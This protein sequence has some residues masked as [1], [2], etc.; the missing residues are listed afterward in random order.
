M[1]IL[2]P[3]WLA[4]SAIPFAIALIPKSA[5]P[6]PPEQ[7]PHLIRK[8]IHLVGNPPPSATTDPQSPATMQNLLLRLK[9]KLL[10]R[11]PVET[12]PTA[13]LPYPP[14]PNYSW[15]PGPHTQY[16]P[17]SETNAPAGWYGGAPGATG[18]QGNSGAGSASGN[19]G[20]SSSVASSSSS[21][22][23]PSL[24]APGF[25][26]FPL[27]VFVRFIPATT[28]CP[29]SPSS[30]HRTGKTKTETRDAL[31]ATTEGKNIPHGCST[32]SPCRPQERGT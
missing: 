15:P 6:S 26:L 1:R 19:A 12:P 7:Q 23:A 11:S 31:P 28:L 24:R 10:Q 5:A 32:L 25:L 16:P 18:G 22:A 2:R 14:P 20:S 4:L 27:H 9:P 21:S 29:S 13:Y 8:A 30:W 17:P 3:H